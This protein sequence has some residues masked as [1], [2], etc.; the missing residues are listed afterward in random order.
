MKA[1]QNLR[2]LV[3]ILVVLLVLFSSCSPKPQKDK[4][5]IGASRA[6]SGPLAIFEQISFGPIYKLWMQEVN[7]AGGIYVKEYDK[8]LPVEIKVYEDESNMDKMVAN[9]EKLI[10]EDKVD[11]LFPPAGTDMLFAAAPIINEYE[12]VLIGAEGGASRLAEIIKDYPYF[13]SVLNFSTHYQVPVFVDILAEKGVKTAA[14]VS[15]ADLH[16]EEYLAAIEPLLKQKGIDIALKRKIPLDTTDMV[17]I[18]LEAKEAKVD[19]FMIFAYPD[20]VMPCVGQSIGIGFNPKV[21]LVGPGGNFQFFAET[22]PAEGVM[23][24]GA[25]NTKVSPALKQF[26]DKL[27]AL[28]GAANM[29][30]WGHNVY[31]ASLQFLQKA[32]EEAGTLDQK[33]LRDVVEKGKFET[34][35]G[36]TWFDKNHLLAVECYSGQLGQWQKGVFEV[37]GPKEKATADVLYP[38]PAWPGP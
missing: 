31:Y 29:D 5:V 23:S 15:L 11:L 7:A 6:T 3:I 8:K 37:I 38:K 34:V 4:I 2:I 27:T 16:G 9:L 10:T 22:F 32:I 13:F 21:Y 26:A 36:P 20:H 25:W 17:P 35:L 19:A 28:S 14:I 1:K 12:Y 30:W 33:K 18:L 24:W